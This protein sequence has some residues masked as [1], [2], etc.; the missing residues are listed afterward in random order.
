MS[1]EYEPDSESLHIS[2]KHLFSNQAANLQ[3]QSHPD[4]H[5]PG[6]RFSTQG[7]LAHKKTPHP[8]DNLRALSKLRSGWDLVVL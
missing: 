1:L 6:I 7:H 5:S 3:H 8:Q 4:E 2:V